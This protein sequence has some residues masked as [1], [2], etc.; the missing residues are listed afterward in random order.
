MH[1]GPPYV[2]TSAMVSDSG[3]RVR[4]DRGGRGPKGEGQGEVGGSE[5]VQDGER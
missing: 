2:M 1:R 3:C 5:C 4:G